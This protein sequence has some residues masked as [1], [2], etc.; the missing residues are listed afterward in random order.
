MVKGACQRV[1][2]LIIHPVTAPFKPPAA[3]L[4]FSSLR[5]EANP[6]R[7]A[8]EAGRQRSRT[9]LK[10]NLTDAGTLCTTQPAVGRAQPVGWDMAPEPRQAS[11][12]QRSGVKADILWA[13][14]RL[15][16]QRCSRN[17]DIKQQQ[18]SFVIV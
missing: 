14:Q 16:Q 6:Q 18:S 4:Y 3:K 2:L 9:S 15:P 8:A 5:K 10:E 12:K 1:G 17:K 7:G 11:A 13:W